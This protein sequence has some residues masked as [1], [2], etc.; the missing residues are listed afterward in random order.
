MRDAVDLIRKLDPRLEVDGEMH[1]ETALSEDLREKLVSDSNL[2]GSANLLVLPSLDAA[3]I[4]YG[5]IRMLGNGMAI[6]P[7]LLGMKQPAHILQ[8]GATARGI[9]NMTA[10]MVVEAQSETDGELPL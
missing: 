6:G 9:I 7:M 5:L 8:E 1:A 4:S 10:L 3:N 2:T